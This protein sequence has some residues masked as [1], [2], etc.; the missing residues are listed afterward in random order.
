MLESKLNILKE[1]LGT[2]CKSGDSEYLFH[3]PKCEHHKHKL[4]VNIE[5]NV[6]KCWVCDW[7]GRNLYR[8]IRNYGTFSLKNEWKR[9]FNQVEIENFSE[10]LFGKEVE[11]IEER[12]TLPKE[13]ISLA[14]KELPVTSLYPLNYLYSRGLT[15]A[16]IV[17]W[18]IG[19][20]SSG[21]YE[22]RIIVPSFGLAGKIN[23]FVARSYTNDWKKYL[24][25][26]KSKNIVFNHLY[27]D[28]D[29]D[30]ILVEGIFDAIVAGSNAV[31]LLGSTLREN[32]VIFQEIVKNDTPVYIAFD[33]D[34]KRKEMQIMNMLLKYDIEIYKIDTSSYKDVGEMKRD[35]FLNKKH[36]AHLI[37]STNFL[38]KTIQDM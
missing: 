2:C 33:A 30:L 27:V 31:P 26:P 20:C 18:K 38:L 8:I 14:N 9:Q 11:N 28:F 19:Y 12:I 16:N 3:C 10:K 17:R 32:H 1:I 24:N 23:Y 37:D 21:E 15:K 4:S 25:P 5:K 34:A 22:N 36:E 29:E 7:S 13:F 35:V 6:F